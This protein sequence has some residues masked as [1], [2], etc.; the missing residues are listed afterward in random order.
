[1]ALLPRFLLL[2]LITVLLFITFAAFFDSIPQQYSAGLTGDFL[3][4][5]KDE[6][7]Q[8]AEQQPGALKPAPTYV[9]S[10]EKSPAKIEWEKKKK[11]DQEKRRKKEEEDKKRKEEEDKKAKDEEKKKLNEEKHKERRARDKPR[12][13][14]GTFSMPPDFKHNPEGPRPDQ[15]VLLAAADGKGHNNGI[16]NIL[17]QIRPNRQ[18]YADYHGYK[19]HFINITKFDIGGAHPVW[20]KLPSI[21]EAFNTYPDAEWVWW[22]DLDAIIMNPEIDLNEHL[23]KHSVMKQKLL[24]GKELET[25]NR[26]K[27]GVKMVENPD[28]ANVDLILAQDQNGVN[29]GSFFIRRSAWTQMLLD[30]WADPMFIN[31]D[32]VALEQDALAHLIYTHPIIRNNVGLVVQNLINAYPLTNVHE[33]G[34][35]PGDLVVHI[36]GCWV[37]NRCESQWNDYMKQSTSVAQVKSKNQG[38]GQSPSS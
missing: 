37:A 38:Q 21:V 30:F 7:L 13:R 31:T 20:A 35:S 33:M 32:W 2:A 3:S 16:P 27:T 18:E 26:R 36:A 10:E 12:V 23:L 17:E 22:L 19:Y 1:M 25:E 9:V 34:Y 24:G 6:S 15:I 8:G 4:K 11:E 5:G 28:P 14:P 29:A